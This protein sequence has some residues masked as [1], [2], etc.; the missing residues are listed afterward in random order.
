MRKPA[1][2]NA[3]VKFI[4]KHLILSLIQILAHCVKLNGEF[5]SQTLINKYGA[6][7]HEPTEQV[8][9]NIAQIAETYFEQLLKDGHHPSDVVLASEYIQKSISVYAS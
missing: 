8:A 6:M 9:A 4:I 1:R 5:M 2:L 7:K 3:F